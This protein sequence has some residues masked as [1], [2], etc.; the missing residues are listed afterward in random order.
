MTMRVIILGFDCVVPRARALLGRN[1]DTLTTNYAVMINPCT[2]LKRNA[3]RC[4]RY[5]QV[6]KTEFNSHDE[7][8]GRQN[9]SR[10]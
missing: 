6:I 3:I 8:K 7:R 2:D 5:L 10:N 9:R 4:L 1:K